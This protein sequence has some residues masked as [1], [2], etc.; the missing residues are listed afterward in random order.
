MPFSI[1]IG[2]I[3]HCSI[4]LPFAEIYTIVN[5]IDSENSLKSHSKIGV[6]VCTEKVMEFICSISH[7]PFGMFAFDSIH[8]LRLVAYFIA[9]NILYRQT[10]YRFCSSNIYTGN[11]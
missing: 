5:H 1:E 9:L 11:E 6:C 10:H 3:A 2:G 7:Q 8:F 4:H